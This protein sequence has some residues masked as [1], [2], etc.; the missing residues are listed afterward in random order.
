VSVLSCVVCEKDAPRDCGSM[1]LLDP[2][3]LWNDVKWM[4]I[5]IQKQKEMKKTHDFVILFV[6]GF[7][8]SK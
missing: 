2:T 3:G 4:K 7:C 8:S 6:G 5:K 1:K